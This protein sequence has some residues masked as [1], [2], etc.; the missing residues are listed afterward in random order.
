MQVNRLTSIVVMIFFLLTWPIARSDPNLE[1]AKNGVAPDS[2][3]DNSALPL[4]S[5]TSITNDYL[6]QYTGLLWEKPLGD[7]EDINGTPQGTSPW[8]R[9]K[10][11]RNFVGPT[12]LDVTTLALAQRGKRDQLM[13]LAATAPIH[14]WSRESKH[15]PRLKVTFPDGSVKDLL[16]AMDCHIGL[17]NM[18]NV[19]EDVLHLDSDDF[20]AF[21]QFRIPNE[22]FKS[23]ELELWPARTFMKDAEIQ[24]FNLA[25]KQGMFKEVRGIAEGLPSYAALKGHPDVIFVDTFDEGR[26]LNPEWYLQGKF[27][28]RP[29]KIINGFLAGEVNPETKTSFRSAINIRYYF[30]RNGVQEPTET[31]LRYSVRFHGDF[32]HATQPGKLPGQAGTYNQCGWGGRVTSLTCE[33][34][35][36]RMR[37][38]MPIKSGP[39]KGL[40]PI[41]GDYSYLG[42][43]E[44]AGGRQPWQTYCV[45]D[46]WCELEQYVKLNTPGKANGII[47]GYH[48]GKLV[49]ER[50][51]IRFRGSEAIRTEDIWVLVYHGGMGYPKKTIHVDLDNIVVSKSHIGSIGKSD[52]KTN[53]GTE[54]NV[55]SKEPVSRPNS[56]DSMEKRSNTNA[57]LPSRIEKSSGA[58]KKKPKKKLRIGLNIRN[59]PTWLKTQPLT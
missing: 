31:Y 54:R 41:S 35:S 43:K 34:W 33:G 56:L 23:A 2:Q 57:K 42:P 36:A 3:G 24:V 12:L 19:N 26:T 20:K 18:R 46:K 51:D 29:E 11:A 58:V 13:V 10:V 6:N 14:I 30:A 22:E 55:F 45:M 4:F 47:R 28:P 59:L 52:S 8:A 38:D 49:F 17:R 7:W 21:I 25:S 48:D 5:E 16:P 15:S 53:D 40:I 27:Y 9:A 44:K 50:E 1:L 39:Y 37:W 32:V